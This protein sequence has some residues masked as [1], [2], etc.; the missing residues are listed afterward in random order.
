MHFVCSNVDRTR[1]KYWNKPGT[2]ISVLY[3]LA[4]IRN[5]KQ[6]KAEWWWAEAGGKRG[7]HGQWVLGYSLGG[8]KVCCVIIVQWV[9]LENN[10][11]LQI[12]KG[13]KK[14]LCFT[15]KTWYILKR[16]IW[17][18]AQMLI[19][20][21]VDMYKTWCGTSLTHKI[22]MSAKIKFFSSLSRCVPLS[23]D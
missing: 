6:L 19:F 12:S 17:V 14:G 18:L 10:N 8:A 16:G 4:H 7:G 9:T 13:F 15:P 5:I 23:S 3:V 21:N 1:G 2:K 20:H 22:Y 11:V